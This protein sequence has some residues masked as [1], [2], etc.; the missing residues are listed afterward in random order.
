MAPDLRCKIL[1]WLRKHAYISTLQKNRKVTRS[2]VISCENEVGTTDGSDAIA[3]S[4]SDIPSPVAVKSVPP[5]R[6][7]KSDVRILSDSGETDYSSKSSV[8]NANGKVISL[9]YLEFCKFGDGLVSGVVFCLLDEK[10]KLLVLAYAY[11]YA[12]WFCPLVEA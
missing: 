6:R 1:K 7:T 8:H 2:S 11:N 10:T 3:V 12:C 5:R 4:K 9:Y